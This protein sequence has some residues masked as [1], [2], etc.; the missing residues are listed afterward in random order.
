MSIATR[1]LL[2]VVGTRPA[3][4]A[5]RL[6]REFVKGLLHEFGTR[7]P[8]MDPQAL[9]TP[10]RDGRNAGVRLQLRSRVPSRPIGPQGRSQA[11]GADVA[12]ARKTNEDVVIGMCGKHLGDAS[13]ERLD[14]RDQRAQLRRVGLHRETEGFDDRR[15]GGE[16][17]SRMRSPLG[18]PR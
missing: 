9:A 8:M 14:R 6:V 13:V 3:R 10:L 17:T 4:K 18:A 11:R 1:P 15:I 2:V 5:N 7:Q 12:G 16:R